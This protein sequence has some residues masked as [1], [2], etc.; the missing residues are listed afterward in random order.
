[1][2]LDK[3]L[4][5]D[6]ERVA[7]ASKVTPVLG[8]PLPELGTS[9]KEA[10]VA[11][12]GPDILQSHACSAFERGAHRDPIFVRVAGEREGGGG[13]LDLGGRAQDAVCRNGAAVA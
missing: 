10:D 9:L 13:R 4:L 8:Q 1:M 11:D 2:L 6:G 3:G 5:R 12:L 7:I